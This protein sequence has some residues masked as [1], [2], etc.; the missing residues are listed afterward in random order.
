MLL[1]SPFPFLTKIVLSVLYTLIK[2]PL[3][4]CTSSLIRCSGSDIDKEELYTFGIYDAAWSTAS[5]I[6]HAYV[7][8]QVAWSSGIRMIP[9]KRCS[10]SRQCR[11]LWK[12][13][14][15]YNIA[16]DV[17]TRKPLCFLKWQIKHF[18][19]FPCSVLNARSYGHRRPVKIII[20]IYTCIFIAEMH[21]ATKS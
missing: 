7:W 8:I 21:L 2:R 9:A 5:I 13:D 11:I 6:K 17:F 15:L 3:V 12:A 20:I 18:E 19:K 1:K 10:T 4:N 14:I 16:Q